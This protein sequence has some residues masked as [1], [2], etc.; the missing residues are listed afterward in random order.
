MGAAPRAALLCSY[1]CIKSKN[2][3]KHQNKCSEKSSLYMTALLA[4]PL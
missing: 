3:D 4:L 1:A 2:S